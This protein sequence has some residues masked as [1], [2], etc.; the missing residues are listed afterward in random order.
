MDQAGLK[1][2]RKRLTTLITFLPVL[3]QGVYGMRLVAITVHRS[4]EKRD[5]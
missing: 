5:Y 4:P 1:D 3:H 2:N